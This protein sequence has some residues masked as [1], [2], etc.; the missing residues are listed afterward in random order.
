MIALGVAAIL[1]PAFSSLVVG[2]FVGW[3]LLSGGI[4]VVIWAFSFRGTGLFVWQLVAGI[5][6]VLA[7]GLLIVF[8][9]QGLVALTL[10]VGLIFLL[11]GVAQTSFA[12]WVR[13]Q[14]GWGWSLVSAAVSVVMG[15][16]ILITLPEASAVL[17]GLLVGIDFLSSGIA[18]VMIARSTRA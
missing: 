15:L 16:F 2:I 11:T 17:L 13:P 6:P 1:M 9:Q 3:L 7:G 10:L 14:L 4:L 18:M 5:V 12:I 8:P